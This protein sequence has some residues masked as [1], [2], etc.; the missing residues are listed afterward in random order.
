VGQVQA[1]RLFKRK[2]LDLRVLMRLA[3]MG[4]AFPGRY[5]IEMVATGP[6]LLRLG[7]DRRQQI[8]PAG[9][10]DSEFFSK[11][12]LDRLLE[13]LAWRDMTAK[14]VPNMWVE[15]PLAGPLP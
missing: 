9:R 8:F 4:L 13:R 14:N 10:G 2:P 7:L 6:M 15:R 12:T 1:H 3:V 11:L 5:P